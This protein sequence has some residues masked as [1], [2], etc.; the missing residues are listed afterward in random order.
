LVPRPSSF[1]LHGHCHQKA[2]VGTGSAL[3]L[4]RMIP[5]AEA[6]E[7]DS[8]CCGMAGSFGYEAEHYPISQA[9]GERALFPAVRALAPAAEVVA[10]GTSCRQQIADGT[11][12]RARHLVEVLADALA[13]PPPERR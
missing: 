12:R 7:V 8:G 10:M 4:L 3:A 1:L 2:L 13:E 5:G 9:I 6:R 11:A